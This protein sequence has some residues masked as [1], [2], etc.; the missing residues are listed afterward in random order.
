M[1]PL[2]D[3]WF[4]LDAESSSQL[5]DSSRGLKFTRKSSLSRFVPRTWPY[6]ILIKDVSK[7]EHTHKKGPFFLLVFFQR[8]KGKDVL[9]L[10]D[11]LKKES[12][13]CRARAVS[14]RPIKISMEKRLR[15]ASVLVSGIRWLWLTFNKRFLL[16]RFVLWMAQQQQP[17]TL[18]TPQHSTNKGKSTIAV[19]VYS[20]S[21][22]TSGEH[23]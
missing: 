4:H 3:T 14:Q 5:R 17:V 11:A 20:T 10:T 13:A 23:R 1:A 21:C 9:L 18:G 2:L 22:M 15:E 8:Q 19:I 16:L 7:V 6:L 12:T